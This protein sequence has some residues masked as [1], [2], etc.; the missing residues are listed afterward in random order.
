MCQGHCTHQHHSLRELFVIC[1]SLSQCGAISWSVS[2]GWQ[3][4]PEALNGVTEVKAT[5]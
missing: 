2:L 5:L 1:W 3:F 4:V